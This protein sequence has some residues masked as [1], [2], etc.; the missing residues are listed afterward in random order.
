[1][2]GIYKIYC[3][4][5][6]KAYIGS[7]VNIRRRWQEHK[8]Q[9]NYGIHG[10]I[11]LQLDWD[12][13]GDESFEFSIIEITDNL[14]EREQHWI[15]Y[16]TNN[17][18]IAKESWNP[19]RNPISVNKM[20]ETK[21]ANNDK[22]TFTQKLTQDSVLDIINRINTGESD[23]SIAKDY[24]VLRGTIWSI[25][26]GNTWRQ[27]QHLI[28]PGKS[29]TEVR[30]EVKLKG[31]ELYKNGFSI[32]YISKELNRSKDTVKRWISSTKTST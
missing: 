8:R 22:I 2:S 26:T 10:N 23:I 30:Q 32:E 14:T 28:K 7:S 15:N 20:M 9:L 3:V 5:E 25:K 11:Y 31:L 27:F 12:C 4:Q 1:M 24:N 21:W 29:Y 6:D 17:Y 13:Y 19:M 16:Y 18:N